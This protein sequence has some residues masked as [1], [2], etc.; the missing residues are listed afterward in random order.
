MDVFRIRVSQHHLVTISTAVIFF[1]KRFLQAKNSWFFRFKVILNDLTWRLL[2][3]KKRERSER[4]NFEFFNI[5]ITLDDLK[6]VLR[7]EVL[8]EKGTEISATVIFREKDKLKK[9]SKFQRLILGKTWLFQVKEKRER[10]ERKKFS[11]FEI[12]ITLDG[13]KTV[14]KDKLGSKNCPQRRKLFGSGGYLGGTKI[15]LFDVWGVLGGT[16]GYTPAAP[17]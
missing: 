9:K 5:K 3:E 17:A 13:L 1:V 11:F 15:P 14:L 2:I 8:S 10:S 6:S 12:K 16:G 7:Y 4:K